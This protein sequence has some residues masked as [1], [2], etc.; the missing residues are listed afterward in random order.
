MRVAGW[1]LLMLL[2]EPT[3][4]C[5]LADADVESGASGE[6]LFYRVEPSPISVAQPFAIELQFCRAGK[7]LP[8]EQLSLDA[9]M[10]AHGHGMNYHVLIHPTATGGYRIGGLLFHMPGLWRVVIKYRLD[11]TARQIEFDYRL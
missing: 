5:G 6:Q 4:A 1:I 2:A 11:D 9:L 3:L 7:S 10:P 8:V